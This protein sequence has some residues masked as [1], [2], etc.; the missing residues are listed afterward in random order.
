MKNAPVSVQLFFLQDDGTI[1]LFF[2]ADGEGPLSGQQFPGE[3]VQQACVRV[4]ADRLGLTLPESH[5][6]V[7]TASDTRVICLCY[8]ML[9]PGVRYRAVFPEEL[10]AVSFLLS[11]GI[12]EQDH[13]LWFPILRLESARRRIPPGDY[14]HFKGDAYQVRGLALNSETL[15]PMVIYQA[16]YGGGEIWVRPASMWLEPVDREDYHGPRFIFVRADQP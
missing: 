1:S 14:R 9:P 11:L 15:E 4:A 2:N 10:N 8:H 5:I 3:T 13:V 12:S 7:L 16:L 6:R